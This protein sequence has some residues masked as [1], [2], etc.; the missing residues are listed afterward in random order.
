M[1]VKKSIRE[2]NMKK[3]FLFLILIINA[4]IFAGYYVDV[5][6]RPGLNLASTLDNSSVK[7][8][9]MNLSLG[10]EVGG[11]LGYVTAGVGMQMNNAISFTDSD[12]NLTG[13]IKTSPYYVYARINVFPVVFKPYLV[14]KVG[15]NKT[16]GSTGFGAGV[17]DGNFW[18]VGFGMDIFNLLGEVTYQ[19]STMKL[20]GV[21]ENMSQIQ[22]VL[23]I[24]VF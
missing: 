8:N 7:N 19:N 3:L 5:A 23:G 20:N 10:A 17:E 22:L 2:D 1:N 18:A 9:D 6:L 12:P 14:Y 11:N 15:L 4:N 24:K 16:A 21:D 13:S